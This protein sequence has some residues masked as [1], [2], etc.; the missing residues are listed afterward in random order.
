MKIHIIMHE[1]FEA[2]AAIE[3]WARKNNQELSFSRLYSGDKLPADSS[4]FDYLIVMGGPQSLDAPQEQY[5]YFDAQ[6]EIAFVQ[7]VIDNDKYV[8]GVYLG[9]QIIG[10]ALGAKTEKSPNREIGIFELELTEAMEGM[11]E[12]NAHELEKCKGLPFVQDAATLKKP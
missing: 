5:P 1:S 12:N 11:I 9:A 4:G 3:I 10:E 2:P 6:A 8:L 7:S